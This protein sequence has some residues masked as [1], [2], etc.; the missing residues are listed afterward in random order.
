LNQNRRMLEA[1][2][3]ERCYAVWIMER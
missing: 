3:E 1:G 2:P